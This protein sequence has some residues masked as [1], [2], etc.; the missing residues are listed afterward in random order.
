MVARAIWKGVIKAGTSEVPV[1][2]YSAVQDRSIHFRLL[3][4]KDLV[5]VKQ[6]MIDPTSDEP[7][8]YA[9]VKKA[10]SMS[11]TISVILDNEELEELTPKESREIEITRFVD[12]HEIDHRWYSR[13]YYLGPDSSGDA[14]FALAEALANKKKEGVVR[15][16]MRKKSYIGALREDD[17][18][19]ML[20]V[21]RHA[22]EIVDLESLPAPAGRALDAR[23]IAMAEQLVDALSGPFDPTQ[24]RDE[25]RERVLEL[26]ER[27]SK[28]LKPKV[29][30]FRPRKPKDDSL[31]KVLAAS[32]ASI[33][34]SKPAA[35]TKT[36]AKSSAKKRSTTSGSK[37]R[38]VA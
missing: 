35:A 37:R 30:K 9:E 28:G 1:K 19:L 3:H 22:D 20:I 21:L 16:V 4:E 27:K 36:A 14:Y 10:Y 7:V 8:E 32:L 2:L 29:E 11:R 31:D 15:F 25:Y 17:G 18:Y 5:P 34:K 23:E 13:A 38:R 6:R 33:G 24:F 12:P 26:V